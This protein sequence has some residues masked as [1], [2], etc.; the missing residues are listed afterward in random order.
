MER[1]EGLGSGD[2]EY[3]KKALPFVRVDGKRARPVPLFDQK[4]LQREIQRDLE[5]YR[6][7]P[8]L[9]AKFA[10]AL[11]CD[12]ALRTLKRYSPI[13]EIGAGTGYWAYLLRKRRVVI[14]AYDRYP[15]H[16]D[17]N[18][19]HPDQRVWTTVARGGPEKAAQYPDRTL[20]LCWPPYKSKMALNAL[21]QYRGQTVIYVGEGDG[22]CTGCDMFHAK[23]DREWSCVETVTLPQWPGIRDR[24]TVWKRSK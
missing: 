10:W 21:T 17:P 23:L 9:V 3:L 22:G 5:G 6:R 14:R 8:D 18:P 15:P 20:F 16:R 4:I 19:F 2:N 24:L 12:E 7:R 13:V 11:P 1:L